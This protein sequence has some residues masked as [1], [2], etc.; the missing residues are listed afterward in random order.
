MKN[1]NKDAFSTFNKFNNSREKNIV[2]K[3]R[4]LSSYD[5]GDYYAFLKDCIELRNSRFCK[6]IFNNIRQDIISTE[7]DAEGN[8]IFHS[9][10]FSKNINLFFIFLENIDSF[11]KRREMLS[12][13]NKKGVTPLEFI[14]DNF[15]KHVPKLRFKLMDMLNENSP[16][17]ST[18][19][20]DFSALKP[21]NKDYNYNTK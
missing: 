20:R 18:L 7:L 9:V 6:S 12:Q 11:D 15:A 3:L 17:T 1:F 2:S 4:V 19:L 8:N 16:S 10:L 5:K 14:F 21:I 13:K